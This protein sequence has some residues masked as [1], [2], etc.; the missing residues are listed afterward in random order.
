MN[1]HNVL[2]GFNLTSQ[3][4]QRLFASMDPHKKGYLTLKD[5]KNLFDSFNDVWS[6]MI[7]VQ[8]S[9]ASA[10]DSVD[11][12]F[13]FMKDQSQGPEVTFQ[14]FVKAIERILPKRYDQRQLRRAWESLMKGESQTLNRTTFLMNFDGLSFRKEARF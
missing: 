7:D 6:I 11:E 5:W 9:F 3:L 1:G 8:N 14:G 13:R 12:A 4:M 10:F 2:K